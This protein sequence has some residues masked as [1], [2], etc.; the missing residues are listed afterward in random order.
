MSSLL[1]G[2]IEGGGTKFV[3]AVGSGPEDIRAEERFPTITPAETVGR[4]IDF[5]RAQEK[6]H[7][8][9]AAVGIATFGPV[10]LHRH[11]P[12][13][14]YITSTPK[15]GWALA[16]FAQAVRDAL[17]VPVGFDTDVNGAALGEGKWGAARGLDTYLYWTIGTGIGGGGVV[18][19]RLI[20]GVLHPEFGHM[21]LPHDFNA[22][23]FPGSCPFH[24]DCLEG[25]A[26]GPAM[27]KRWGARAE[28]LP[29]D[30]PAWALE[31][32]Y[33][34]LAQ[35][36]LICVL[37][38]QRIIMGGGVMSQAQLLPLI[39]RRVQELLN[40]YLR[41]PEVLNDID[42]YIV[43]PALGAR[44]GVLGAIALAMQALER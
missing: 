9:L 34:A 43:P 42:N 5:F 23:P 12:T 4:A 29:P 36:N 19:G 28:T 13:W 1:Y 37:S 32:E 14:G 26:N 31:A 40:G 15:P 8:K 35:V 27:E 20:H 2:G 21:R 39:R 18:G 11:S 3:C 38:P 33:L 6:V 30:H 41:F 7:G 17:G 44:A 25:L 22:D 16:N 10:D 24:G